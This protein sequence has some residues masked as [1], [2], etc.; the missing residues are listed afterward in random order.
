V[1]RQLGQHA[2][3]VRQ[4]GF[5]PLQQEEMVKRYVREHGS[6]RRSDVVELCRLGADQAKRLLARL[7]EAGALVRVGE[8][9]GSRYERGPNI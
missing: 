7:V 9:K 5:D 2:G 6:I 4:A 3:Y 8:G 1:Y